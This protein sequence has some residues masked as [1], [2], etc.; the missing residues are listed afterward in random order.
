M[1]ALWGERPVV[2]QVLLFGWVCAAS[3]L[4][5]LEHIG[6][7][8]RSSIPFCNKIKCFHAFNHEILLKVHYNNRLN[9]ITANVWSERVEMTSA[10]SPAAV[11]KR[12]T[13]NGDKRVV[14]PYK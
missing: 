2:E 9:Q 11:R 12:M 8:N 1:K 6:P 13:I 14:F 5:G 3:A 10:L 7:W 4:G